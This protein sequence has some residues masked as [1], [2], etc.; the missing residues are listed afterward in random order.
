M[1]CATAPLER[2]EDGLWQ[3]MEYKLKDH[4]GLLLAHFP[5]KVTVFVQPS[6][7]WWLTQE[8]HSFRVTG[9]KPA[10]EWWIYIVTNVS[11]SFPMCT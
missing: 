4:Q 8:K 10:L 6:W 2:T 5:N 7:G 9:F 3:Q 1:D 11:Q